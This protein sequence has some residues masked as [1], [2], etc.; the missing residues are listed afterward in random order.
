MDSRAYDDLLADLLGRR[1]AEHLLRRRRPLRPTDA[2][3]VERDGRRYVNFSA[4][5]YL[6]LTHHPD[7]LAAAQRATQML[8]A[9]S[10]AAGLISGYTEAHASAEHAFAQWKGTGASVLL[11]SGYQANH[12]A[13][14][15]LAATAEVADR[16]VRFLIDRLVH[17][18]LVDAVRATG[19]A[20]RVFPHN[21]LAKVKRLLN[22]ADER[23]IDVVVTESIFSMDGDAADLGGLAQLKSQQPFLLLVDEAHGSGVY[24]PNGSG[25]AAECGVASA[26][27]V[28]VV[29]LS[30]ALGGA[31]GL[32]CASQR[33]CDALVE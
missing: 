11:P 7:V 17:A 21:D 27:D 29:T 22:D 33:F 19:A 16:P 9:G 23:Q 31:G 6:G 5:N 14:Q 26:V 25:Y 4:N 3:H 12:A 20:F 1:E 10:G 24:G 28:F 2:G 8:G 32:V 13:V 15:T 18:S 30:K